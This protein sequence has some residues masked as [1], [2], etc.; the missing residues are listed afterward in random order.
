MR[1]K[2]NQNSK[3]EQVDLAERVDRAAE[4]GKKPEKKPE[5][6]KKKKKE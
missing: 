2:D 3:A 5:K 6:R 1:K 4:A